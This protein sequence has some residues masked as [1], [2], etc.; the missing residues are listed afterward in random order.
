MIGKSI[1]LLPWVLLAAGLPSDGKA[2]VELISIGVGGAQPNGDSYAFA[3]AV[4]NGR[5]VAFESEASNLVS[6]DTNRRRDVFVRDRVAQTTLRVSVGPRGAQGNDISY[7]AAISSNGRLVVFQS[8]ASN[9]VPGDTNDE[10]DLFV[11]DLQAGTTSRISVDSDERQAN[12]RSGLP[13]ITPDG[14]FVTFGSAASNLVP[15][16]TNGVDDIFLRDRQAGKTFRV[17]IGAGFS[18][19]DGTSEWPALSADADLIAFYSYAGNLVA[20]DVMGFA[21][22][23]VR[24]RRT[25]TVAL[26]SISES[27]AQGNC[28][29]E[30][31]AMTPD[32]R[33]VVFASC[34][35]N[36]V[37]ND[38]NGNQDIFV[39]DL[40]RAKTNRVESRRRLCAGFRCQQLSG[41]LG[42]RK[43]HR[44]RLDCE[45]VRQGHER[46]RRRLSPQPSNPH[47]DAP[48]RRLPRRG[49]EFL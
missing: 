14:Q 36:L 28:H 1:L 47:H 35:S 13:Q 48:E 26:V 16:D 43:A 41:H 29:S 25:R 8:Y 33:F 24:D 19:A 23:F 12:G 30:T 4:A 18:Q 21:D 42:Q 6:G 3:P 9:L 37:P 38:T 49:G 11:R 45:T 34:A 40:V 44:F 27:G 7:N 31:P 32:G 20:E 46:A 10:M 2:A 39:R 22:V 5:Y 15:R 17:S